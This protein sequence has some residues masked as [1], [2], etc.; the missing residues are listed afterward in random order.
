M[1]VKIDTKLN[2]FGNILFNLNGIG[3]TNTVSTHQ[4]THV[5][6]YSIS[7]YEYDKKSPVS[8]F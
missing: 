4:I 2:V 5:S 8:Y 1:N 7:Y 3:A 6:G